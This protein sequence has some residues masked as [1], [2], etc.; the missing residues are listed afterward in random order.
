MG[1]TIRLDLGLAFRKHEPKDGRMEN[2]GA[3]AMKAREN[4]EKK[5]LVLGI[6]ADAKYFSKEE[7]EQL[8]SLAIANLSPDLLKELRDDEKTPAGLR[9]IVSDALKKHESA[10]LLGR[11]KK[12][13]REKDGHFQ[14]PSGSFADRLIMKYERPPARQQMQRRETV[15]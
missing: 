5:G 2:G 8:L 6:A 7:H 10:E 14:K 3:S 11:P 12:N 1:S 9:D 15:H 4:E 13:A